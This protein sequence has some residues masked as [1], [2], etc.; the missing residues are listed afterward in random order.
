[1]K[2]LSA[3]EKYIR[4]RK[5]IYFKTKFIYY[6][7]GILSINTKKVVFTA[8]E[9]DGGYCCNPRYIAEELLKK[10]DKFEIVWLVNN[11]E[12]QFPNNIKK[13]EN[14]FFNRTYHL[15]T[16]KV[17]VDNSR[18]AYGTIKRKKQLYIQTWHSGLGF[19]PIGKLR[20]KLFPRIW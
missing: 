7:F 4:K 6:L 1:M 5:L 10:K 11:M 13:V 16:A 20:G 8:F 18:K 17:W 2:K 12:K 3:E 9:G 15:A 19:K 14:T